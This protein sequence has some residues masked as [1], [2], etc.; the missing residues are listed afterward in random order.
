MGYMCHHGIVVTGFIEARVKAAHELAAEI[1]SHVTEITPAAINGYTSFFVPPDGS[2]EGWPESDEGD[3]K[4][5]KFI[6]ALNNDEPY[7]ESMCHY[8]DWAE[9]QYGDDNNQNG[10]LNSSES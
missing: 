9:V 2:K 1:F 8:L 5:K 10:I 3:E 6:H 7:F 4:R